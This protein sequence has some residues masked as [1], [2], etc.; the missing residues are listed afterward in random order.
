MSILF[1]EVQN[2]KTS[3]GSAYVKGVWTLGSETET[4]IIIDVQPM[5]DREIDSLEIG[6]RDIGKIKAYSNI[7]LKVSTEGT[8]N[9]G[10]TIIWRNKEYEIIK[11]EEHFNSFFSELNHYKYI[12]EYRRA[13]V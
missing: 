6:R 1:P 2:T 10:D 12:A 8:E 9:S 7:E 11:K 3:T 13:A 5:T 4:D